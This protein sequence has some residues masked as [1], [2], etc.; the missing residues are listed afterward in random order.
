MR[1]TRRAARTA[2]AIGA[3]A[4]AA[5]TMSACTSEPVGSTGTGAAGEIKI[6]FIVKTNSNPF[7]VFMQQK[8]EAEAKK[9]GVTLIT[10]A[11][12]NDGDID[13]QVSAIQNMITS[14]AKAIIVDP[15]DSAAIIPALEAAQKQGVATFAVDTQVDG[16][17]AVYGT[18]ATDNYQGG[19]LLGKYVK[20]AFGKDFAGQAPQIALLDYHR[21]V[22]VGDQRR[23]GFLD[24]FG[25]K[26][27]SPEIVGAQD[28]GGD[29]SQGQQVMENML[30]KAPGINVVYS[31]N[32]PAGT[33]GATAIADAGK[34]NSIL[35]GS[36]DGGCAGVASVK[37]GQFT[38]TVMQFP[39]RMAE[40][41]IQAAVKYIKDGTKPEMPASGYVDTG[42][43]LIT[44]NAVDGV[45][46]KDTAWGEANCWGT[47]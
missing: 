2:A 31:I 6:G 40:M 47:K 28:T 30:Q 14:G 23:N 24:G 34:T 15:N 12:K 3:I 35:L 11:G 16:N 37:N 26:E 27:G 45:E 7:W 39:A 8:A 20:A 46:S 19:V 32:E 36:I 18:W 33:G 9:Q 5:I 13:S 38:A 44:D 43:T 41:S 22:S 29:Q 1:V 17:K 42:T 4:L 25:V 21:G 10:A